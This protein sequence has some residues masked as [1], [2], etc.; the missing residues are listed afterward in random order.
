MPRTTRLFRLPIVTLLAAAALC[1]AFTTTASGD[2]LQVTMTQVGN[3]V[4]TPTDHR[5]FT[6]PADSYEAFIATLRSVWPLHAPN[7][8]IHQPPYDTEMGDGV[9]AAGYKETTTFQVNEITMDPLGIYL[10]WADIPNAGAPTGSSPDFE[11]GP[12]IPNALYS[13]TNTVDLLREGVV[14]TSEHPGGR[15]IEGVD[16]HSHGITIIGTGSYFF[17][18]GTE[19]PGNYEFRNTLR[20]AAGNGWDV[21]IPFQVVVPEPSTLAL[22]ASVLP[23]VGCLSMLVRRRRRA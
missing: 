20:D 15:P 22:L 6:A 4:W 23:L 3:P 1:C 12:I 7:H 10:I 14:V 11:S 19:L 2:E 13:G 21:T 16:G 8:I 9:A 18:D 5:L 17:P